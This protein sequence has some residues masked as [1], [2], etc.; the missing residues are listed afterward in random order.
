MTVQELRF[1]PRR[2]VK[3]NAHDRQVVLDGLR[4]AAS[5]D[6]RHVG[7][8]L[9]G[10]PVQTVYGKTGTAER[11]PNPDQAWYA[12]FVKD[13]GQADRGH[14]DR[15]ARRLRCGNCGTRGASHPL[16][17]VRCEGPRVQARLGPEQLSAQPIQ[18]AS[19]PPPPL[20]PREWRLRLDPL[21]LLATLGLVAC[22]L[23]ALQGRDA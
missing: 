1:K 10:L 4:R 21:L 17:V 6:E 20:V 7:R 16:S 18:P 13:G 8:R 3:F 2:K 15:R 11:Q 14:R 5:E 19:E 22:S 9:Q 12:C 23:I